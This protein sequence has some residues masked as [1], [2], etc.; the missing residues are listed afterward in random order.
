[1]GN[2]RGFSCGPMMAGEG[3]LFNT[4]QDRRDKRICG[5]A[6]PCPEGDGRDE[7]TVELRVQVD[8]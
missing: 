6:R 7:E 3:E 1:M 2:R 5:H 4:L 8:L